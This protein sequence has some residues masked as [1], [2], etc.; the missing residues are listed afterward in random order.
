MTIAVAGYEESQVDLSALDA[1]TRKALREVAK[2]L[3]E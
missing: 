2:T 1:E 3:F